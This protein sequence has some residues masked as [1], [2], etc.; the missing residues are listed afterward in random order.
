VEAFVSNLLPLE[1]HTH[2][3]GS[4]RPQPG[5]G[6]VGGAAP[7][8][9]VGPVPGAVLSRL[10]VFVRDDCPLCE[11]RVKNLEN[12]GQAFDLYMVG[13]RGDDARIRAWVR[14]LRIDPAKVRS[15]IITL[16]HDAGRWFSL[17]LPGSLP[18]VLQSVDGRWV[19]E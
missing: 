11:Q 7:V 2:E 10:A 3:F 4:A 15:G 16:N 19:R 12:S 13:T 17:G 5:A 1:Q 8:Q 14:R 18:A 6:P 9:G